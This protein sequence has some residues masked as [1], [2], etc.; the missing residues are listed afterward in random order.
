MHPETASWKYY[1]HAVLPNTA[2]DAVTDEPHWPTFWRQW[3]DKRVYMARWT[4][5]FD[6]EETAWWWVIKD[7]PYQPQTFDAS[8]RKHIRQAEKRCRVERIEADAYRE[9]LWTVYRE[10]YGRYRNADNFLN[11]YDFYQTL[12]NDVDYWAAFDRESEQMI[13]W[14]TCKVFADSVTIQTAKYVPNAMARRP[15]D[16][17]HHAVCAYYLNEQGKRFVSAGERSVN[18]VTNSQQYK[19]DTFGFRKA[20]CRLHI[21][22]HGVMRAAVAVLYPFRGLVKA[23]NRLPVFHSVDAVLCMEAIHRTFLKKNG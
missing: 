22:Y 23:L 20:Y 21:R 8:A 2:S 10:A 7:A 11:E 5:D 9:A 16:A 14:M 4:T 15:S 13:G 18:H 17:I 12:S 1:H 19:M 3:S 6:C